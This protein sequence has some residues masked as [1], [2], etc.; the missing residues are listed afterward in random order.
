[1][2]KLF[3]NKS[4]KE[5][6]EA[7]FSLY[8][9]QKVLAQTD[10]FRLFEVV[11]K[12]Y[13]NGFL[14]LKDP[15]LISDEDALK[16]SRFQFSDKDIENNENTAIMHGRILTQNDPKSFTS[17]MVDFMRSRGYAWEF[18]GISILDQLRIDLVRHYLWSPKKISRQYTPDLITF[19]SADEVFVFGSNMNGEHIGG[20]AALAFNRYGAEWGFSEGL[21][22]QS[23]ALPTLDKH[24]RQLSKDSFQFVMNNFISCVIRNQNKIFLLTKVGCGIAGY[25]E[26]FVKDIFW[27]AIE[28]ARSQFDTEE[29]AYLPINLVIPKSFHK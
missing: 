17:E 28:N 1:M 20:A 27:K 23:Y 12:Y 16:L 6:K 15:C 29:S 5:F 14:L 7:L 21:R 18:R 24:F 11:G 26:S 19:L 9:K 4:E 22:K 25:S 10:D 3:D 2:S 13:K 8:W